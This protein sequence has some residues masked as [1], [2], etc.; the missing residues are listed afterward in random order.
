MEVLSGAF[1]SSQE[2]GDWGILGELFDQKLPGH[3][4]KVGGLLGYLGA[5][6]SLQNFRNPCVLWGDFRGKLG[7]NRV[8]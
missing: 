1:A 8:K 7:E 3:F 5:V 4:P 6:E 2:M